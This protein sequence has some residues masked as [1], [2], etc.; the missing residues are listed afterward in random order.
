MLRVRPDDERANGGTL[1]NGTRARVFSDDDEEESL[2]TTNNG[3]ITLCV[4]EKTS[5]STGEVNEE[6]DAVDEL[7]ALNLRKTVG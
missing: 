4:L 5:S 6:S 7:D 1:D 2:G 3:S